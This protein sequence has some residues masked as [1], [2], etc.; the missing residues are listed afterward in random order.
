MIPTS[1]GSQTLG[2]ASRCFGHGFIDK[3]TACTGDL[4]LK[5]NDGDVRIDDALEV[6]GTIQANGDIVGDPTSPNSHDLGTPTNCWQHVYTNNIS[7]CDGDLTI[8][9]NPSANIVMNSPLTLN[10]SLLPGSSGANLGATGNCWNTT[11]T[12]NVTG[13]TGDLVLSSADGGVTLD[14]LCNFH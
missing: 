11:F 12:N 3:I 5:S 2:T 13:C 9:A 6:N 4:T 7:S 14:D 1:N 8:T 10:D